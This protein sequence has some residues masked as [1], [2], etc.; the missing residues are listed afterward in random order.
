MLRT[1]SIMENQYDATRALADAEAARGDV[2]RRAKA[3]AFYYPA[4]GLLM[5]VLMAAICSVEGRR[6]APFA[7]FVVIGSLWLDQHY[8][9][10]T[11]LAVT[12]GRSTGLSRTLW[13]GYVVVL[14]ILVVASLA[15]REVDGWWPAALMGV[16]AFVI[17]V[18]LGQGVEKVLLR[19][20]AKEHR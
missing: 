8:R 16:L 2:S 13:T 9:R 7:I 14:L 15:L 18:V 11:G 6:L 1:V 4:L 12:Y 20:L 5:G 10:R 3:P 19:D 17:T